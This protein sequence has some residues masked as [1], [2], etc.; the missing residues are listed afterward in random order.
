MVQLTRPPAAGDGFLDHDEINADIRRPDITFADRYT[1]TLG[2]ERVELIWSKNRH[3]SDLFDIYFPDERVLFASDYV[4]IK[5]LC[6][7]FSFDR[8]P[9]TTWVASIRALEALDFDTVINSHWES[10]SKTDL[11]A[12]RQYLEELATQVQAGITAGKSVDELNKELL[13]LLKAQFGLRMQLATQQL[14][15]P[16]QMSKVRRDIARVRTLIREKAV[17]Q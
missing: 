8:R 7:N 16:S 1:V 3:T 13:D 9:I 17:Q 4:W 11:V 2:G 15:N 6:C 12:F 5:R 10:G 14:S